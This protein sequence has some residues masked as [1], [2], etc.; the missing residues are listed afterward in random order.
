MPRK[1]TAYACNKCGLVR[2]KRS[3]C[4]KHERI[5][6]K[7]RKQY[8]NGLIIKSEEDIYQVYIERGLSPMHE[9]LY[10]WNRYHAGSLKEVE[11]PLERALGES[12]VNQLKQ[13]IGYHAIGT[14]A[15]GIIEGLERITIL[16]VREFEKVTN[17]LKNKYPKRYADT[18][19][20]RKF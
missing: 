13:L 2:L 3:E 15:G 9:V 6:I 17:G 1:I 5:P 19:F 20:S 18:I 8:L 11:D 10:G 7:G 12:S 4:M 16:P 14:P